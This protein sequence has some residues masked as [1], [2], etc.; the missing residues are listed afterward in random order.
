MKLTKKGEYSLKALLALT[1]TYG[2]KPLHLH[3]ISSQENIPYKFLEQI[4]ILLRRSGLVTSVK[5]KNGGYVLSKQPSQ[6]TLGEI[7]RAIEGP[8]APIGTA[9][10]I[11]EKMDKDERHAGLYSVLLDVRN[12]VSKILDQKTLADVYEK[13][14][15]ASLAKS[16][17]QMYYI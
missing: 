6:T 3:E 9:A 16:H 2:Q 8:L 15:E 13:T 14:L 17:Y 7:I 4:M 5:G 11:R 10:E 12:A 1:S